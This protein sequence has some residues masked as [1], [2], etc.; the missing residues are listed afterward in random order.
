M[1]GSESMKSTFPIF[2]SFLFLFHLTSGIS[3]CASREVRIGETPESFRHQSVPL[4]GAFKADRYNFGNGL[5]LIVVENHSSPTFAYQTWFRVGSRDEM[6]GR[7][8]LAHLFEHMM[9]K[10]TKNYKEGEFDRILEEAGVE[11][12]NA[13][14][15]RDYTTY[16]QELP[17]DKLELIAKLESDRMINLIVDDK[18]FKT[19]TEVVQN[20]RRFRNENSPDGLMY[21]ELFGLAFTRHPYHWP[22]IGY[23]EDLNRM[24][25][26]DARQFYRSYY[27]PNHATIVVTGD[28]DAEEVARTVQK[29]YGGIPAQPSPIRNIPA[30]PAQ[31]AKRTKVMKLNIQVEKLLMGC[32]TP[33]VTHEDIP[34]LSVLQAILSGGKSSRLHRA[35]VETGISSSVDSNDMSNKDPTLFMIA[36][37][38]QSGKKASRAE[39]VIRKELNRIFHEPIPEI[40]LERAKNKLNFGFYESMDGNS[41]RAYFV[42]HY[43]ALADSFEVG[44]TIQK[45]IQTVTALEAQSVARR[46][47]DSENC[48]VIIGVK[49]NSK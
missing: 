30:E 25:S 5:R 1:V 29:F 45:R 7:T 14:T 13:F 46:Y 9:F 19:E 39:E 33:E 2:A 12:E 8:G 22:I 21:Q 47:L 35:L 11:G 31:K 32:H 23:Q 3:G 17:K 40:E 49:R 37:N 34:A 10:G 6:K 26:E 36:T 48:S 16:V 43:E 18:A 28:V 27:S 41:S 44:L 20:E 15:S 24:N 38:L 4:V 42:G